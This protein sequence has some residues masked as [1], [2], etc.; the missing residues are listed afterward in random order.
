M[1]EKNINKLLTAISRE[2]FKKG[3][4]NINEEKFNKLIEKVA[5]ESAIHGIKQAE[6]FYKDILDQKDREHEKLINEYRKIVSDLD[7]KLQKYIKAD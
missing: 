5:K 4:E 1:E 6:Y 3:L 7:N 2:A